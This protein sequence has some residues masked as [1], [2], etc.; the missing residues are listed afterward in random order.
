[1]NVGAKEWASRRPNLMNVAVSRAKR[2]L[3]VIGNE[4]WAARRYFD[5]LASRLPVRDVAAEGRRRSR[6]GVKATGTHS[7]SKIHAGHAP[8][9]GRAE[10]RRRR[11]A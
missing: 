2:R 6:L 7:F 4:A 1:M 3:Y 8:M 10:A 11:R 5:V 9:K